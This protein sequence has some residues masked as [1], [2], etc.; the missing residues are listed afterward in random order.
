MNFNEYLQYNPETGDIVWINKTSKGVRIKIGDIA[1]SLNYS[2]GIHIKFKD[3]L[4]LAHRVAWFLYYGSWPK[5]QI[6]HIN[7]IR[8]DNRIS[9]LRDVTNRQN[10]LNRKYHREKTVKYYSFNKPSNKWRVQTQINGKPKHLGLF[11]TEELA[12]QF[13]QSNIE[14]FPGAKPRESKI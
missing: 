8:N 9:N 1:G 5:Y 12:L 2:G 14:L 4:Y 13:I 6:D 7:G 10:S 11:D 3:K